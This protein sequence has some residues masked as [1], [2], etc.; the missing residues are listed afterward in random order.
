MKE[1]TKERLKELAKELYK[2]G[3]KS[4]FFLSCLDEDSGGIKLSTI[5]TME[6][7]LLSVS[8]GTYLDDNRDIFSNI[9]KFIESRD[10]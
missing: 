3:I 9:T 5:Q 6:D 7:N 10:K 1:E 8:L 4:M 2:D